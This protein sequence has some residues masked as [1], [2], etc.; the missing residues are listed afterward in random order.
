MYF[1]QLLKHHPNGITNDCTNDENYVCSLTMKASVVLA[2]LRPKK[3]IQKLGLI[4]L[5]KEEIALLVER[6][7][8]YIQNH[9][10]YRM[11]IRDYETLLTKEDFNDGLVELLAVCHFLL[12]DSF[13]ISHKIRFIETHILEW[14]EHQ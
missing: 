13:Q 4:D 9:S 1:Y 5:S 7:E 10:Y 14:R 8:E 6:L 12:E 2:L 11:I 3:Y